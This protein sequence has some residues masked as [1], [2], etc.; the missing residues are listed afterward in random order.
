[1]NPLDTL[2]AFSRAIGL[3]YPGWA[4]APVIGLRLA[5]DQSM[6]LRFDV[7]TGR[8]NLQALVGQAIPHGRT[9]V[10]AGLLMANVELTDSSP[11]R[12]GMERDS[13]RVALGVTLDLAA[14]DAQSL[15][16]VVASL[17][18][19]CCQLRSELSKAQLIELE[20][21]AHGA[22]A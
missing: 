21:A 9:T 11:L 13:G 17:V 16:R 15:E 1:M 2:D 22:C 3:D 19:T 12:L 18:D 10:M 20:S 5:A 6:D 14:H 7:Q 4:H 8:L